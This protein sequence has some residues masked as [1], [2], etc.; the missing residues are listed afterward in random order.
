MQQD[1]NELIMKNYEGIDYEI[2]IKNKPKILSKVDK[3]NF[4]VKE[5]FDN[6]I[7]EAVGNFVDYCIQQRNIYDENFNFSNFKIKKQYL[8]YLP[9]NPMDDQY[10]D[11]VTT[12]CFYILNELFRG[13]GNFSEE[14]MSEYM[15]EIFNTYVYPVDPNKSNKPKYKFEPNLMKNL[16]DID[17]VLNIVNK[18]DYDHLSTKLIFR[19]LY[20]KFFSPNK[21]IEEEIK[22]RSEESYKKYKD[23]FSRY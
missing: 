23:K 16:N 17:R 13:P 14:E 3:K 5:N 8:E 19:L 4:F 9:L 21:D 22:K 2:V 15:S 20:V 18:V 10:E 11:R 12:W 6:F 1:L 7:K